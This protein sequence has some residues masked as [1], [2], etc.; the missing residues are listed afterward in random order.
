MEIIKD[1]PNSASSVVSLPNDLATVKKMKQIVPEFRSD[2]S[3]YEEL[4][5]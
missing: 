3:I 5:R 4:D 2:N 1:W